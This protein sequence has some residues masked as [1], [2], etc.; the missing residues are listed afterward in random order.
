MTCNRDVARIQPFT[1]DG[2]SSVGTDLMLCWFTDQV[3]SSGNIS[4]VYS[5]SARVLG[6][7]WFSHSFQ[8][9]SMIIPE[10]NLHQRGNLDHILIE[11]LHF[12]IFTYFTLRILIHYM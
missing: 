2:R 1:K 7:A 12:Y 5:A 8:T 3:G 9:S 4:D 11:V 6:L 10:H